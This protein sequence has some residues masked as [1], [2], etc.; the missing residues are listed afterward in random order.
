MEEKKIMDRL[1]EFFDFWDNKDTENE[2]GTR[3]FSE[4][5]FWVYEVSDNFAFKWYVSREEF[6][7]VIAHGEG[8]ITL[9]ENKNI[10][11]LSLGQ[12]NFELEVATD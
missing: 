12:H 6:D 4:R 7:E 3:E 8:R 2:D 5:Q 10:A 9:G 11:K 1:F